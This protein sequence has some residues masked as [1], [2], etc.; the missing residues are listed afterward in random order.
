M[1]PTT[2]GIAWARPRRKRNV[3]GEVPPE[4]M[5]ILK[6]TRPDVFLRNPIGRS[7]CFALKDHP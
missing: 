7:G 6:L 2:S 1:P 5:P 4:D 3:D